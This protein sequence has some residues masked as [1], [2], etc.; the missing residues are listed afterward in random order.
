[1]QLSAGCS[2]NICPII[3]C[4]SNNCGCALVKT[5]NH[6]D[7]NCYGDSNGSISLTTVTGVNPTYLWSNGKTTSSISGIPAGTYTVSVTSAGFGC[8]DIQ[9]ITVDTPDSL[10]VDGSGIPVNCRGGNDGVAVATGVGGTAPYSLIWDNGETTD[11]VFNKLA[12]TYQVTITDSHGCK[13]SGF[14]DV[15]EP[16]ADLTVADSHTDVS[17]RGGND[18]TATVT[19]SGG[20]P[21]YTYLWAD[22]QTTQ[23][24]TGLMAGNY[25]VTVTDNNGCT[26]ASTVTVQ[27]GEPTADLT[28][29]ITPVDALCN[30]SSDGTATAGG[31]GGTPGYMYVWSNGQTNATA[32]GLAAGTYTVTVTDANGCVNVDQATVTIGEPA[33]LTSS[34]TTTTV[35]GCFGGNDG[36]A[37]VTPSG[38][39]SPYTYLWSNGQTNATGTGFN[40]GTY[41]VTITDDHGC[42]YVESVTINE[43]NAPLSTTGNITDVACYGGNDGYVEATPAGGTPGYTYAWSDGQT[44]QIA[45]GFV[46][47]SYVVTV[48]DSKGCTTTETFTL[49]QPTQLEAATDSTDAPCGIATGTATVTASGGTPAYTYLWDNGQT[50]PTATGLYSGPAVVTIT[51]AHGCEVV[52]TA[53]VNDLP[54]VTG[55]TSSADALCFGSSDGTATVTASGGTPPY[56]YLWNN[57][58][59]NQLAT[60]LASGSYLVTIT[61]NAGCDS[62]VGV[63]VN[64]PT[65]L[66][67][68]SGPDT[69][70]CE[71]STFAIGTYPSGGTG[72]YA[73]MWADSSTTAIVTVTPDQPTVYNLTVTDANGCEQTDMV[74]INTSTQPRA[75]FDVIW[76]PSCDGIKGKFK[77]VSIN[78]T[79]VFWDFGDGTTSTEYNPVHVFT[80]GEVSLVVL[81]VTN[82]ACTDTATVNADIRNYDF[83]NEPQVPNVFSPNGDGINDVFKVFVEGEMSECTKLTI[84]NRWGNVI[85]RPPGGQLAWDGYTTA[86]EKV[87]EGTYLYVV[88][89]NG[90]IKAGTVM[91]IKQ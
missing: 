57:G 2:I 35:V 23:T 12:G 33:P 46:T 29:S 85:Y 48:T 15:T 5:I 73:Y 52:V 89:V 81:K 9:T 55:T 34:S 14:Y 28:T 13:G 41:Q 1:M 71:N 90:S 6:N 65:L 42:V 25:D 76:I 56:T 21:N 58:Q 24:A 39:T 60:G 80:Y 30:G 22:G 11:S 20:T 45:S 47:G 54:S 88:D 82:G 53:T 87:P 4:P 86:G 69:T 70:V 18:G 79:E 40:K 77:D 68:Q 78:A 32:T 51:D 50:T 63:Q 7:V 49:N 75:D 43:P 31:S 10:V 27:V 64:E 16:S 44:T 83:Y 61:D 84:M 59:T 17:C 67:T 72:P 38:G 19:P 91:L 3:E 26:P 8:T 66:V 37:T 74:T 62:V 36:T